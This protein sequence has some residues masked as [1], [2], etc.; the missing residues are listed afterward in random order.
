MLGLRATQRLGVLRIHWN[1][2][3]CST[4]RFLKLYRLFASAPFGAEGATWPRLGETGLPA[5]PRAGLVIYFSEIT[6][7]IQA[8]EDLDNFFSGIT[9]PHRRL[10][11]L[12]L[13]ARRL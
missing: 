6:L 8:A 1:L 12:G 13:P 7:S 3:S 2:G 9:S 10:S 4:F 11:A 5:A